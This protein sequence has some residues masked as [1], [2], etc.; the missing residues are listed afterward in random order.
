MFA[1][2]APVVYFAALRE[3][4]QIVMWFGC[5]PHCEQE[6]SRTLVLKHVGCSTGELSFAWEWRS[7]EPEWLK[8][9]G[10]VTTDLWHHRLGGDNGCVAGFT[11]THPPAS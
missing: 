5:Q 8:L 10:D 9:N 7:N 6:A 1:R 2:F 3:M 11:A 4:P